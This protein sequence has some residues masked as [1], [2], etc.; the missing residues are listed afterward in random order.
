MRHCYLIG[1]I[2]FS[3]TW[4]RAEIRLPHVISDGMVIQRQKPI[5]FWGWAAPGERLEISFGKEKIRPVAD[6]T[7]NWVVTF[8]PLEAG[9][10]Y[11][12]VVKG[13]Q[14]SKIIQDILIG[15]VWFCSG[16]SNMVLPMER[17]KEK[18]PID[19]SQASFPT[20]RHFFVPTQVGS[21][22]D[23]PS[24][25][26]R[27]VNPQ[28]VLTMGGL[29][30]FFAR[31]LHYVRPDVPIGIVNASVGGTPIEAWTSPA[32]L[33]PF[34]DLVKRYQQSLDTAWVNKQIKANRPG[35]VS[36]QDLGRKENWASPSYVPIGWKPF[37]LPGYWEDQGIQNL[38]GVVWFR[39]EVMIPDSL[40]GREAKLF[41]G[42]IV[43]SDQ[44]FWNG[45]PV[46]Q[47]TYQYP[48]RR[49][50]VPANLVKPGKNILVIRVVN[51]RGKGGFVPEK[52]YQLHFGVQEIDLRGEWHYRVGE[53][54]PPRMDTPSFAMQN[55]PAS[56]FEGM[57][58]PFLRLS[59]R[60]VLWYQGESNVS[61]ASR[62][63]AL[64]KN[65]I[66]DWRSQFQEPLPFLGVQLASF[67]E[68]TYW[69][70]ESAW[71]VLREGQ[72]QAILSS[73]QSALVVTTDV[74]EWNDIHPLDKKTIGER[75]AKAARK[76]VYGED[77]LAS[78]PLVTSISRSNHQ[79]HLRFDPSGGEV[80][81]QR[82]WIGFE[83]AGPN[84]QFFPA[85][86]KWENGYLALE[87]PLVPAPVYVRYGWSDNPIRANL[88]NSEGWPASPFEG[89]IPEAKLAWKGQKA[90]VVLTYDDGLNTH[91]DQV[92]PALEARGL[93]GT[94]YLPANAPTLP[95]RLQ[96]WR[97]A[98]RRGHELGNHTL[99]H[100]CD[101]TQPGMDWVPP[102]YNLAQYSRRR[103]VDEVAVSQTLLQSIDGHLSRTLA[104]TC[105][106]TQDAEGSFVADLPT[107]ISAV[108]AVRSEIPTPKNFDLRN[109]PAYLVNGERGEELIAWVKEAE[110]KGGILVLVFHGVGGEHGLD[111]S[112][113]A[114]HQL[115]DYLKA[116][117]DQIWT[118][119]LQQ[120]AHHI[121]ILK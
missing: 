113:S 64:L 96:D 104:L 112:L 83:I 11:R 47:I 106:H 53:V 27:S 12:L 107:S 91:L 118:T 45:Q 98:A 111:V 57:V 25:R 85:T 97:L 77:I 33:S 54:F 84:R 99:F 66:E 10:P 31:A 65:M 120:V 5:Q 13:K 72:R 39:K 69:P 68:E 26:W 35:P 6:A 29:T 95:N 36:S 94:F 105:G 21:H 30:F 70:T 76:L 55:Q 15:D 22:L 16:Q 2:V 52:K 42:R 1:L 110:A 121:Q 43:D 19:I 49:Y 48:P 24:T 18:Y 100:P 80:V 89:A 61:Q 7:G 116:H 3:F 62:Y 56:L 17:L 75:L 90:A 73:S 20:I 81:P 71:A 109:V 28:D 67:Q 87:H 78:G 88:V 40:A 4:V 44:A 114:H 32:G 38:D 117:E 101:A 23:V 119:T 41:L 93:V 37:W 50:T 79:I 34:P 9:G 46:G 60:G 63:E 51:E 59:F 103:L 58:K 115:L 92:I 14:D 102:T 108:R 82:E 86:G 8:S 74:G